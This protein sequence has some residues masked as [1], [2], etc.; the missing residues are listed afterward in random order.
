MPSILFFFLWIFFRDNTHRPPFLELP[1]ALVFSGIDDL[2]S[3]SYSENFLQLLSPYPFQRKYCNNNIFLVYVGIN[4]SDHDNLFAQM[5][6]YF[7]EANHHIAT[8]S[9]TNCPNLKTTIKV[10]IEHFVGEK[11]EEE[12]EID[13]SL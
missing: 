11:G 3:S 7:K 2:Y 4:T 8:L 5:A 6:N 1:T 10:M 9:S 12:E 13:V